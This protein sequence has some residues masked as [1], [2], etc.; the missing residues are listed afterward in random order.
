MG[1]AP[2][3]STIPT[4]VAGRCY[5]CG[6]PTRSPEVGLCDECNPTG[7]A[8]PTATQVHGLILASVAGALVVM[9]VA[10]K[11][12][13]S[14]GGPFPA[15]VVG[16]AAYPDGTI[17][18]VMR[19]TNE[20]EAAARPACTVLRGPGDTGVQFLAERIEGGASVVITRR[21]AAL[22]AGSP[23]GLAEVRCR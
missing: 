6:R 12:L 10:A 19:I 23:D 15:T 11:L 22:P 18:I 8:G 3:S 16:Q 21:V 2:A 17:E 13:A 7:I 4:D 20:G 14:D 1:D 9:A 5:R